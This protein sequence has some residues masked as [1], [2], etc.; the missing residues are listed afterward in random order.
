MNPYLFGVGVAAGG[1]L[2][3]VYPRLVNRYFGV[4][5]WRHLLAADYIRQGR[6][7][8][9]SRERYLIPGDSDYPPVLRWV[10]ACLPKATAERYERFVAPAFD[11]LHSLVIFSLGWSLSGDVGI[12]VVAQLLHL[13]SPLVAVEN[14]SLS[15]RPLSALLVSLILL[16]LLGFQMTH[17]ALLL[18]AGVGFLTLLLLTHRLAIQAYLCVAIALG[19]WS[20]TW[21]YLAV[22]GAAMLL[23][24]AASRGFY[25]RILRGQ[26]AMFTYWRQHASDR[27]AHQV[28]GR[29]PAAGRPTSDRLYQLN[30]AIRRLPA[31]AIVAANPTIS[32]LPLAI[33]W[34]LH[35]PTA[36]LA[37]SRAWLIPLTVWGV[38]LLAAGLAIRQ[39]RAIRFL[40][41]GERYLD[42]AILPAALVV[43]SVGM[44]GVRMPDTRALAI[45]GLAGVILVSLGITLY[46]Q[47][48]VIIKDLDRSIKP[49]LWVIVRYLNEAAPQGE[50]RLMAVPLHLTSPAHYFTPSRILAT[51]NG[52]AHVTHLGD[53]FPVLRRPLGEILAEYQINHLLVNE[54][55]VTMA[56]L[57]LDGWGDVVCRADPYV[58]LRTR[59]GVPA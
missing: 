32:I 57:R 56:E 6:A 55:Y 46:L 23:A 12:A 10:L 9:F 44:A 4:D 28:R 30:Q 2:L 5:A 39:V 20:R 51:D 3:H 24:A 54:R 42:Y 38:A 59:P 25:W 41:D 22:L 52:P 45:G 18:A 27:Y 26:W 49:P 34:A 43:A 21:V 58:L 35:H 19:L 37:L 1:F 36:P 8:A 53:V 14:S 15:A 48:A 31:L 50:I 11:F 16:T 40:G 33:W 13:T 7:E 29:R 17:Q 47:W